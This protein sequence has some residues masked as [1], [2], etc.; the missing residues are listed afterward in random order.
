[1]GPS[2]PPFSVGPVG[3]ISSKRGIIPKN[4]FFLFGALVVF[5]INENLQ[6]MASDNEFEKL[7]DIFEDIEDIQDISS[8]MFSWLTL[9]NRAE[10]VFKKP[11]ELYGFN[12]MHIIGMQI[13]GKLYHMNSPDYLLYDLKESVFKTFSRLNVVSNEIHEFTW[14]DMEIFVS[15]LQINLK[16]IIDID[17][18]SVESNFDLGELLIM[19]LTRIGFFCNYEKSAQN[20]SEKMIPMKDV[21]TIK[22]NMVRILPQSIVNILDVLHSIGSIVLAL[23]TSKDASEFQ[24]SNG[25]NSPTQKKNEEEVVLTEHHREVS[26]DVFYEFS[27]VS[28]LH[29]GCITQYYHKHEDVFHSISQVL[30]FNWPSYARKRQCSIEK[31]HEGKNFVNTMPL[32]L[33]YFPNVPIFY[34]HNGALHFQKHNQYDFSWACIAGYTFLVKR[35][36]TIFYSKQILDYIPLL[37]TTHENADLKTDR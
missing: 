34:E 32:I 11:L 31:I 28:D 33:E 10:A 15:A 27:M 17:K 23:T 22:G 6:N 37:K 16:N 13:S 24:L 2:K 25:G 5:L 36:F 18:N 30:Y 35:D 19:L 8:K 29:A 3:G 21:E 12:A 7:L 14:I 26:L 20:H 9:F 1:V 4:C